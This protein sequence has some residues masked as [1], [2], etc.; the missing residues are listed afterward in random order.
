MTDSA[1]R[2]LART[3]VLA[4]AVALHA[5]VAAP[6]NAQQ[7]S[8]SALAGEGGI[9]DR[10]VAV[11]GD[12]TVLASQLRDRI[13]Q[14]GAQGVEI[15]EDPEARA[16]LERDVLETLVNEQLIV[17]AA[18]EDTT[19]AVD[20]SRVDEIVSADLAERSQAFGGEAAM[21]SAL[22][23][24][25]LSMSAFREML[26]ADARRQQLQNQYLQRQQQQRM[27]SVPV[28]EEEMRAFFEQNRA[29]FGSRPASVTFEQVV[30]RPRAADSARAEA[31]TEAERLLDML[32]EGEAEFEEL[33]RE[34]SDDPGT[35][36]EGGSLGWFRRGQMVRDF[37][38]AVFSL[39]EGQVSDVVETRFGFHII[40]VDRVRGAE[41]RARHIL[42]RPEVS[43]ES[44]DAVRVRAQDLQRR[45]EEGASM[46]SLQAEFDSEE[47]PDS[48]TVPV[49]DLD[50]LPPGY[51][52]ALEGADEGDVVG[53][54][55]W[56]SE[57][58]RSVAVVKVTG[59]REAGEVGF[60]DVRSQIQQRLQQEK[61]L[62]RLF[63]DL[64]ERTY[65][66]IRM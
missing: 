65:V 25:G 11:V 15:P 42:I 26:R 3:V 58:Q 54:V 1:V 17:Q 50:Q 35:R 22:R 2:L 21:R 43:S 19:I 4:G 9:V 34:Y 41:R 57:G 37:E 10:I 48:L 56:G 61:L 14:L 40:R 29:R 53:P 51:A 28:S 46:D 63:E 31:R 32:R 47:N 16:A 59:R 44:L 7:P 39:R 24:E 49:D 33:A 27:S 60:E 23:E 55:E 64:R 20:E 30:L 36:E 52:D 66:D 45:I 18:L 6:A 5:L 13:R 38:D 62:E 8:A 12:S